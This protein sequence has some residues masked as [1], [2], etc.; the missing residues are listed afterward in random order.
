MRALSCLLPAEYMEGLQR[1][2]SITLEGSLWEWVRTAPWYW[3][4]GWVRA[5]SKCC[6]HSV[7]IKG[8]RGACLCPVLALQTGTSWVEGTP[9]LVTVAW[10]KV[11]EVSTAK[12]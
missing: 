2:K 8:T 12:V 4:A 7:E 10:R 5:V 9:F 1:T 11:P 3:R 6:V